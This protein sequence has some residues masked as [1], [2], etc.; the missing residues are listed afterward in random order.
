MQQSKSKL[1]GL[2]H[3]LNM[4]LGR[5]TCL[6]RTGESHEM[7]PGHFMIDH[8]SEGCMLVEIASTSGAEHSWSSRVPVKDL[9]ILVEGIIGGVLMHYAQS[10]KNIPII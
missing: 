4:M 10:H 5:P 2:T 3:T 1:I 8:N 7:N 6:F 9:T